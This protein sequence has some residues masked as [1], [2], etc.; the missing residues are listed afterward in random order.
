[1]EKHSVAIGLRNLVNEIKEE[2]QAAK[3]HGNM[4]I[5]SGL[6]LAR[7]KLELYMESIG[8]D[9]PRTTDAT[10]IDI[11]PSHN[12]ALEAPNE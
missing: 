8:I 1:M 2:E 3:E 4:E 12:G 6:Q 9:R 11:T 5:L 7:V 10:I